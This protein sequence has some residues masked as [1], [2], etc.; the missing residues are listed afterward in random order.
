MDRQD[1]LQRIKAIQVSP[2]KRVYQQHYYLVS[3]FSS[4]IPPVSGADFV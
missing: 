2:C 4:N 3:F 1:I